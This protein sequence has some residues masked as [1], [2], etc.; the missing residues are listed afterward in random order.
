VVNATSGSAYEPAPLKHT[1]PVSA[2][3]IDADHLTQDASAGRRPR[4]PPGGLANMGQ[5]GPGL[6]RDSRRPCR[7]STR[8]VYKLWEGRREDDAVVRDRERGVSP[9]RPKALHIA[10]RNTSCCPALT[11]RAVPADRWILQGR[12]PRLAGVRFAAENAEPSSQLAPTKV[13]L[14]RHV[15]DLFPA[16]WNWPDADP[17]SA[18]ISTCPRW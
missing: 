11:G 15:S 3:A 2:A 9:I 12:V 17:Y 8:G 5:N 13:I 7:R 6:A 10:T 4:L 1:L 16:N 14:A 18:K